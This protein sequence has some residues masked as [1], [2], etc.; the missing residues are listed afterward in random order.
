MKNK[1][2]KGFTIIELMIVISIIAIVLA[3][4]IPLC[5]DYEKA[6][7]YETI[8]TITISFPDG[9]STEYNC[10]NIE[11]FDKVNMEFRIIKLIHGLV[12]RLCAQNAGES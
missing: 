3:V 1:K 6:K 8:S 11:E 2:S 10:S 5:N 9:T 4:I 12:Y 7:H